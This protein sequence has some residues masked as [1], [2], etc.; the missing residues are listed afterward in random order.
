M[1]VNNLK[2]RGMDGR[3]ISKWNIRKWGGRSLDRIDL[4][5]SDFR[6]AQQCKGDLLSFYRSL[7]TTYRSHVQGAKISTASSRLLA[8]DGTDK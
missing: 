2:D 6:L 1:E 5:Q 7:G 3:I 4:A 8:D